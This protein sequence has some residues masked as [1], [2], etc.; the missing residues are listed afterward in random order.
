[1]ALPS[2]FKVPLKEIMSSPL[3]SIDEESSVADAISLM[4][5]KR[6]RRL[7]VKKTEGKIIGTITLMSIIGNVPSN[8]IDLAD[9]ELP[10]NVVGT[11]AT[12]IICPYC[13]SEFKDKAEMSKH[14]DRIH[15]GSGLLEGDMRR[16]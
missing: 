6:I 3:I 8:S 2:P 16:W 1:V 9:I 15:I 7:A 5:R 4:R 14:I 11:E 13:H 10:S 12:K